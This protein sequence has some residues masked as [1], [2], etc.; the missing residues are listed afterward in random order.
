MADDPRRLFEPRA[1][2]L[3]AEAPVVLEARDVEKTFSVPEHRVDTF[4][5]RVVHPFS[6]PACRVLGAVD[7][8]SFD[9]RKGEFFGIVGRNGSG[10]ST[11]LKILASIYRADA[12]TIRVAGRLAP[13][14]ELGVGF[15]TDLTARENAVLNAVMMG[16]SP[17]EARAR[18]RAVF[19]FAELEEFTEMKLKNFSSGMT[20]R[21]AFSLMLQAD[22]D[23]LLIDEVLA[24]GDAA[25]QQKCA[26]VFHEM[27]DSGKTVILVTHDMWSVQTYCH[28]AMLMHDGQMVEVGEPEAIARR[29]YRLNFG[30]GHGGP[31]ED[32]SEVAIDVHAR[33]IEGTLRNAEGES[34]ANVEEGH[35][36]IFD[37][38]IEAADDLVKPC[39]G[40]H[41]TNAQG[42]H[43][44]GSKEK[45]ALDGGH[46]DRL[47]AG[48]RVRISG[49]FENRLAPGRYYIAC[50]VY[51][52]RDGGDL[53]LQAFGLLDFVVFGTESVY[54]IVKIDGAVEVV[55]EGSK[56]G[57]WA[58]PI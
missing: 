13:F 25:F 22:A 20:V 11:L 53:A 9:V 27:R 35:P 28:R 10:K 34:V 7:G 6:R 57:S 24:V 49:R 29:Y 2:N 30:G 31:T 48:E 19:E 39:F 51:R 52:D 46:P 18:L 15:N 54:G 4:K 17:R 58:R 40:F 5:E 33:V 38:V 1:A 26:D 21:L 42:V 37:A 41:C 32:G 45:L 8:I 44:F 16:L 36:I 47:V 50:W 43:V 55:P 14:I 3:G 56:Q 23:I 12:G